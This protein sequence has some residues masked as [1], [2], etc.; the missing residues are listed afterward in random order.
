MKY[1]N[2]YLTWRG[3][4]T[5][6]QDKLNEVDALIF[7]LL[8]YAGLDDIF[9]VDKISMSELANMYD[10]S[11]ITKQGVIFK[12]VSPL[13][14]VIASKERYKD[15]TV[16]DYVNILDKENTIQFTAVTFHLPDN[17][18]VVSFMGTDS[19]VT[20][21]KE[22]FKF[23]AGVTNG[24]KESVRYLNNLFKN[25]D[26][27]IITAGH[28]KGANFAVYSASFSDSNIRNRIEKVYSFDGPGLPE[29]LKEEENYKSMQNKIIRIVP[30]QS[31]IGM[32]FSESNED[33][34]VHSDT[35]LIFQHDPF[36]WEI[37]GNKFIS[38]EL[39]QFSVY[40]REILASWLSKMDDDDRN[41]FV[42]TIFSYFENTGADTFAQMR[43]SLWT[44]VSKMLQTQKEMDEDNKKEMS[45]L[46]SLLFESAFK[47]VTENIKK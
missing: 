5:F 21:W 15:V 25:N 22:D 37:E 44:T 36:S 35:F 4:L 11:S 47:I 46:L 18:A 34:I 42:D 12:E 43:K 26:E 24:Q 27:K 29:I 20:G 14:K 19:T 28:S 9:Q 7:S 2:D 3:D 23:S 45:K 1:I 8:S 40:F 38:K 31:M 30:D 39:S 6:A 41:F 16:S 10:E 32:I 13:L 17:T 33:I